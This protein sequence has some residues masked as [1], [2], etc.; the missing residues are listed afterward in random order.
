MPSPPLEMEEGTPQR[1]A[2]E[3]AKTAR[4]RGREPSPVASLQTALGARAPA[5]LSDEGA[6]L[7]GQ[8]GAAERGHGAEK[9]VTF[10]LVEGRQDAVVAADLEVD[11]LFH[12]LGDGSLGDDDADA[13]LDGAQHSAVAAE[14]APGRGHHRVAVLVIVLLHCRRAEFRDARESTP[15]LHATPTPFPATR[16]RSA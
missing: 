10:L 9:P 2:W 1:Q 16:E 15:A 4:R 6:A 13:R 8:G 11:L 12:A 7:P 14:H 3:A 5:A